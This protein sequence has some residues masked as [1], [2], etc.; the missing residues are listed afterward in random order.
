MIKLLKSIFSRKPWHL[1][2]GVLGE[3]SVVREMKRMGLEI[4][5]VNYAIHDV[6]EID[7]IGRDGSCLVFVE[8]K[9]RSRSETDINRPGAAVNRDKKL[10]L[11]RT[12]RIFMRELGNPQLRFRFDVAEVYVK[13]RFSRKVLYLPN[14]FTV[15]PEDRKKFSKRKVL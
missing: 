6:G 15:S 1:R 9:T 2:I 3:A 8:V 11:W 4:L 5:R 13:G 14:A 7:I 10:R 12:S